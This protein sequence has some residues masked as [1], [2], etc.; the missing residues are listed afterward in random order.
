MPAGSG[1]IGE[2]SGFVWSSCSGKTNANESLLGT[3]SLGD[4]HFV[5]PLFSRRVT[6]ALRVNHLRDLVAE[7]F[8]LPAKLG[9]KNAQEN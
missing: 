1:V 9:K 7:Q 5:L 4:V 6:R 3:S 2:F 8:S